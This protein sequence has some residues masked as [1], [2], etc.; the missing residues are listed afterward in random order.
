MLE[1]FNWI[2]SL[3]PGVEVVN[4][5]GEY[6]TTPIIVVVTLWDGKQAVV[7]NKLKLNWTTHCNQFILLPLRIFSQQKENQT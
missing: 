5:V 1:I 3:L 4:P 7:S 2:K 6:D